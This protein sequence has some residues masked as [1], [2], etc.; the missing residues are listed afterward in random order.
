MLTTSSGGRGS[1]FSG[2]G[3]GVVLSSVARSLNW[4]SEMGTCLIS[5]FASGAGAVASTI[6]FRPD[7][8]TFD[9][10]IARSTS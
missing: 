1:A 3:S 8:R 4:R 9:T 2:A 6:I 5:G 7:E 10:C